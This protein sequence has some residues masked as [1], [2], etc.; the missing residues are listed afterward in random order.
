ME[1]NKL[2]FQHSTGRRECGEP[3]VEQAVP[4]RIWGLWHAGH[5]KSKEDSGKSG[6]NNPQRSKSRD[7][8]H[9]LR[10]EEI[11]ARKW[12]QKKCLSAF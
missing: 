9:N 7:M 2:R 6:S 11:R 10:H 8:G 1:I 4:E 5:A 3:T 12:D